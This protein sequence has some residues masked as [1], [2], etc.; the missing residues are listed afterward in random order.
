MRGAVHWAGGWGAGV[1]HGRGA[2]A[3]AATGRGRGAGN[4]SDGRARRA[5]LPPARRADPCHPRHP[6][7][8]PRFRPRPRPRLHRPGSPTLSQARLRTVSPA[9]ESFPRASA[10]ALTLLPGGRVCRACERASGSG[11]RGGSPR[12]QQPGSCA[13]SC[14]CACACACAFACACDACGRD[15]CGRDACRTRGRVRNGGVWGDA[16]RARQGGEQ[17]GGGRWRGGGRDAVVACDGRG[18]LCCRRARALPGQRSRGGR[19][20]A[21]SV[22]REEK[23]R[24]MTN[25]H[26]SQSESAAANE[27]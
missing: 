21:S 8:R 19:G 27:W 11:R 5:P 6:P 4:G 20:V 10:R 13:R 22:G 18:G 12:R 16:H 26:K 25:S 2:G 9:R 23:I 24:L 1:T 15:A 7:R 3:G 17:A 14:A